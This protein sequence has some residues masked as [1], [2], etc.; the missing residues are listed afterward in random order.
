[1]LGTDVFCSLGSTSKLAVSGHAHARFSPDWLMEI[2]GPSIATV[3]GLGPDLAGSNFFLRLLLPNDPSI[4]IHPK[5]RRTLLTLLAGPNS[6]GLKPVVTSLPIGKLTVADGLFTRMDIE[7]GEGLAGDKARELIASS[8]PTHHG[9]TLAVAGSVTGLD[10]QAFTLS[11]V[12]PSYAVAFDASPDLSEGDQTFLTARFAASPVW[13]T[14]GGVA[15]QVGD[16]TFALPFEV[17]TL[18]G[19]VTSIRCARPSSLPRRQ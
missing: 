9:L 10:G 13:L 16:A 18:K 15:G 7:A 2:G 8:L 6:W 17:E 4:S 19:S 11:L 5:P 1:M 14:A 3:S 12:S